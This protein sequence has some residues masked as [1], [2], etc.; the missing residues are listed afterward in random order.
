MEL[1]LEHPL[2]LLFLLL[3]PL[4]A[5]VHFYSLYYVKRRAMRFANFEAL[6]RVVQ[7]RSV[8]PNNLLLLSMR[9]LV[10]VGFTLAASGL[11]L[12]YEVPGS[13]YDYVVAIDSS[14]SMLASDLLPDRISAATST[15]VD[16]VSTLP[17]G[18]SVGIAD[19]S[20]QAE[21]LSPPTTDMQ[22][23]AD[24]AK[25][26]VAGKSGGTALCEALK[27]SVNQLLPSENRRAVVVISDGQ[28]NA[29]CLLGDGIEY[30]KRY[31]VTVFSI[32]VGSQLGGRID[33]F[34]D[35]VFKLN[36]TDLQDMASQTGGTY[37]RAETRQQLADS[38][39]KIAIPG[40]MHKQL[41]LSVPL[42]VLSFL[43]VFADWSM[44]ITR[45][46]TIP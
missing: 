21:I 14:S 34:P 22:S 29:G 28:N 9:M 27:A 10:L 11:V 23:A 18:S 3:L 17:A 42:M 36:E 13:Y 39:S 24:S 35:L 7:G 4:L 5:A 31:N 16:W 20:S 12:H 46:R 43:L 37:Y 15:V 30:A 33:G 19:F 32:G 1:T 2:Y 6:E 26:L 38:L 8:V 25:N 45:Y 44:S 41:P 40:E